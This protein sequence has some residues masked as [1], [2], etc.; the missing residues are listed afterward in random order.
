MQ[1]WY[2]LLLLPICKAL[3]CLKMREGILYLLTSV[4]ATCTPYLCLRKHCKMLTV[5]KA[6]RKSN[7]YSK[8]PEHLSWASMKFFSNRNSKVGKYWNW[9][10]GGFL[11]EII[12]QF[13]TNRNTRG[14]YGAILI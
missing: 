12:S 2:S 5:A 3:Y 14:I 6:Q 7:I 11:K 8:I 9:Q 1:S 4:S 13:F 10:T